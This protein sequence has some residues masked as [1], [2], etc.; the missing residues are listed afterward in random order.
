MSEKC[1]FIQNTAWNECL[2]TLKCFSR[3]FVTFQDKA[4]CAYL[5]LSNFSFK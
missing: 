2:K 4:I 1:L 3:S 5:E